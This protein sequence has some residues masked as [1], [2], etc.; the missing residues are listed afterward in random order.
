MTQSQIN[1]AVALATGE[2]I[3]T[4]SRLG[5]S[6][7]EPDA[8]EAA[9]EP[10]DIEDLIIDWDQLERDREAASLHLSRRPAERRVRYA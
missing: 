10:I 8:V 9:S 1:R 5:F 6:L 2:S 7:A 3:R 4:V